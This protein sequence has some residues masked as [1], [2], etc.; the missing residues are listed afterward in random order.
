MYLAICHHLPKNAET[1][2]WLE[3]VFRAAILEYHRVWKGKDGLAPTGLSHYYGT[4]TGPPPEVKAGH[5]DA[6]YKPYGGR[7]F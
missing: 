7:G 3:K 1:K 6:I 5:L 4:G 2:A